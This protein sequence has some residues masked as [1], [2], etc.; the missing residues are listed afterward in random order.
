[1]KYIV[2]GFMLL[3]I[4]TFMCNPTPFFHAIDKIDIKLR[5]WAEWIFK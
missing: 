4:I 5:Q 1:M 3:F 2:E